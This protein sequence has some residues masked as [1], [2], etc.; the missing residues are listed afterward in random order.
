[1][2]DLMIKSRNTNGA[3]LDSLLID[4]DVTLQSVTGLSR[5]TLLQKNT[6]QQILFGEEMSSTQVG[7]LET[8]KFVE[9]TF[10]KK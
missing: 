3:G 10:V 4:S 1:M 6:L 7:D 8:V 9:R 2:R 5:S